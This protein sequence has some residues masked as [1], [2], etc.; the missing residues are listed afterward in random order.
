MCPLVTM[1]CSDDTNGVY[2]RQDGLFGSPVVKSLAL[3][4]YVPGSSPVSRAPTGR[5]TEELTVGGAAGM[6]LP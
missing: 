1:A 4:V 6:L 5:A 2:M 3:I